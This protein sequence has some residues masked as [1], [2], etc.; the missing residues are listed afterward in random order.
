MEKPPPTL[1]TFS[2]QIPLQA[3]Q[4]SPQGR[5]GAANS[6]S[7]GSL[8]PHR[9][10]TAPVMLACPNAILHCA[11]SALLRIQPLLLETTPSPKP[12]ACPTC[13]APK[14]QARHWL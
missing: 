8:S 13:I 10:W 9:H 11:T 4:S 3:S 14:T 7:W 12:P 1:H 6:Y 2:M 5:F